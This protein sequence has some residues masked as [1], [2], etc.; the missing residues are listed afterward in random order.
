M[1][2]ARDV[3]LGLRWPRRRKRFFYKSI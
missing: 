3:I 2:R 1:S